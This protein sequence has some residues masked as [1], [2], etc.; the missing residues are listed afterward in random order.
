MLT[1]SLSALVRLEEKISHMVVV[2]RDGSSI[3]R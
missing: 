1:T 3:S 2:M